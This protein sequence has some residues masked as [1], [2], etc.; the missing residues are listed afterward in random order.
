MSSEAGLT[1]IRSQDILQ[2]RVKSPQHLVMP[3]DQMRLRTQSIENTR[4][5]NSDIPRPNNDDSL[6]LLFDIKE[7]VR[8]YTVFSTGDGVGSR[9]GRS[10]A[11]GDGEDFGFYS[12][13][14]TVSSGYLDFVRRDETGPAF[15]VIDFVI[16]E[17]LL[18]TPLDAIWVNIAARRNSLDPVQ[19]LDIGIPLVLQG[20][21]VKSSN[22]L[23][24]GGIVAES[25]CSGF[26]NVIR[27][28][29]SV[30][31]NLYTYQYYVVGWRSLYRYRQL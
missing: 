31:H 10:A 20:R 21:P 26:T 27:D 4:E 30:P 3:N 13:F 25:V 11:Y 16:D 12:V 14:L 24:P 8:V 29:G 28:I 22:H 18:A 1:H 19:A 23:V 5:L 6:G 15:V 7:P 17:I 2:H 9:N